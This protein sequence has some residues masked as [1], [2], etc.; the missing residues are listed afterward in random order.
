[1]GDFTYDE[2]ADR[3]HMYGHANGNGKAM[4]QMY[5]AQFPDRRMLDHIIF[6]RLYR[7]FRE[8]RSSYVTRYDARQR[9]VGRPSLEIKKAP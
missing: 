1:M 4:L 8:T 6:Q 9:R 2:N 5:H 3:H 7:Q